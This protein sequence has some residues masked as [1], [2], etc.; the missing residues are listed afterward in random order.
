MPAKENTFL[1]SLCL[2]KLTCRKWLEELYVTV[3]CTQDRQVHE[4]LPTEGRKQRWRDQ[5]R[6]E[7]TFQMRYFNEGEEEAVEKET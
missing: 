7:D 2:P 5:I 3:S 4:N 6:Q 1:S